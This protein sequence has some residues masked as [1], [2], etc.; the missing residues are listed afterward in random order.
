MS[1]MNLAN[2]ICLLFLNRALF[3]QL[4]FEKACS[5]YKPHCFIR[6]KICQYL[7]GFRSALYLLNAALHTS[8]LLYRTSLLSFFI[9]N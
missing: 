7:T 9:S 1:L 2:Y 4:A 6:F 3:L 5:L 8:N